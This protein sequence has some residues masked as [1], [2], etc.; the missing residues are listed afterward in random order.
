MHCCKK[1]R[2]ITFRNA[3]N[4]G[5]ETK[6]NLS[7]SSKGG[8]ILEGLSQCEVHTYK[9][10]C[11]KILSAKHDQINVTFPIMKVARPSHRNKYEQMNRSLSHKNNP[12][13]QNRHR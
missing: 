12:K 4:R 1:G 8:K 11:H 10:V 3:Q 6:G 7:H 13:S 9:A 2:K 5:C